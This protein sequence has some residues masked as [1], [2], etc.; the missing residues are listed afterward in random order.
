MR[1]RLCAVNVNVLSLLSCT[2]RY[3]A[4]YLCKI[5]QNGNYTKLLCWLFRIS[6]SKLSQQTDLGLIIFTSFQ[7]RLFPF[8][9]FSGKYYSLKFLQTD[10]TSLKVILTVHK[11]HKNHILVNWPVDYENFFGASQR[12]WKFTFLYDY[13]TL[14]V[15]SVISRSSSQCIKLNLKHF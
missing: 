7:K 5:E 3:E 12:H 4:F 14:L 6:A 11:N 10:S 13:L 9:Q 8:W 15:F 2:L 1:G